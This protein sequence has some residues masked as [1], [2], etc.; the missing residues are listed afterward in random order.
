VYDIDLDFKKVD[1]ANDIPISV[2]TEKAILIVDN[3]I[4]RSASDNN[5]DI[6]NRQQLNLYYKTIPIGT[7]KD[8]SMRYDL[9]KYPYASM[10]ENRD[11]RW[12][13]IR[14]NA[15]TGNILWDIY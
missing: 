2:E 10:T 15:N 8:K 9:D 11:T 5:N 6:Q 3:T 4:K 14:A 12:V 7:F 13:E 1:N